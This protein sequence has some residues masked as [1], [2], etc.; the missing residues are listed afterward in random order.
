MVFP[1]D[2]R[3]LFRKISRIFFL[4]FYLI[5]HFSFCR[6]A[7]VEPEKSIAIPGKDTVFYLT[8]NDIKS[9]ERLFYGLMRDQDGQV[10]CIS[11]H[12][13]KPVDVM[14][15]SPS[16]YDIA[17][18]GE[19]KTLDD[20]QTA[21]FTPAGKRLA[22]VHTGYNEL[23][24]I[25][26]A[27]IKGFLHEY[28]EQGGYKPKPIVNQII[29][30]IG[31]ILLFLVALL[32]LV[33]FKIIRYR[34]VHMAVLLITAIFITKVIVT[35]SIALGRSKNYMPDQPIKFSHMVHAGQ[36]KIDCQY[37]HNSAEFAKSAGI[38]SLSVCLN[39]HMIVREGS[40]SGKF[41]IN[42]IFA[43]LDDKKPVQWNRVYKLPD[44]VFFSHAQ[45]VGAGKLACL[46][47]HGSVEKM[48]RIQQ[49]PDL[50]MGWCISCHRDTKVQ[51]HDNKFYEKYAG[52]RMKLENGQI[53]SVTVAMIGGT[54]C[55]KCHY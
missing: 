22:E 53:D 14:N 24:P 29:L 35:E 39:C 9:G 54:D 44:H 23:T 47:C 13:I 10:S 36:N 55:M 43:A 12:N 8:H 37:C 34:P 31:L 40:R 18:T 6:A 49:V 4:A 16:A 17:A 50:S 11:C 20:L 52:L 21:L 28:Y 7:A 41:E 27:Q 38:P 33:W 19:S 2:F 45:H 3:S 42:K 1:K 48:D 5:V 30:F 51:F 26:L 25:E 46:T 15:W 32:D